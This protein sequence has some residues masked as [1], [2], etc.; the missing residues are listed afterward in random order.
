MR[1]LCIPAL[2][3][4][5]TAAQAAGQVSVRFVEA[6]KFTD[7][8]WSTSDREANLKTIERHLQA[9]GQRHLA[10]GQTLQLEITDVDLAGAVWPMRRSGNEVRVLRG[11]ADWPT[12]TLRYVLAAGGQPL[13]SGEARVADMNYTFHLPSY[14]SGE[15]L[16]HE[17]Q[18]L[19][20]WFKASFAAPQ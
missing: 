18:M 20:A 12:V 17:K 11:A 7:I 15:P 10:D 3:L 1:A 4:S 8:G 19:D 6:E 2:L 5:A 9:L 14:G 16:R 13:K